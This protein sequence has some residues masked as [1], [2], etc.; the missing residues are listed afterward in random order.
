MPEDEKT[1]D[2]SRRVYVG[3]LAYKT[4]WQDLKDHFNDNEKVG[5][6]V[7]AD[8][9]VDHKTNVPSVSGRPLSKGCGT[10]EF[11]SAEDA[12]T[13]I[14]EMN[15]TELD[16]RLI[17][18]REDRDGPPPP[19]PDG[20]GGKGKGKGKD[21]G[22]G[23]WRCPNRDC[24]DLQFARNTQCRQ[25][26][27][28]RP[29]GDSKRDRSRSRSRSRRRRRRH[30]SR[31]RRKSRRDRP[32]K[33]RRSKKRH[34]RKDDSSRSR[35]K[36]GKEKNKKEKSGNDKDVKEKF[37][38]GKA[39]KEDKKD[40]RDDKKDGK[41]KRKPAEKNV[42]NKKA[43][44]DKKAKGESCSKEGSEYEYDDYATYSGSGA[45][46]G[47]YSDDAGSSSKS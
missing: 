13:A 26:G 31:S 45:S 18:V 35:R 6:V 2:R 16:G 15:D 12:K 43:K 1:I 34:R 38:K 22:A 11:N 29:T 39:K 33:R 10:V 46:D 21:K 42:K 5:D 7:S 20:K 9:M 44:K 17:F 14:A 41:S 32:R 28:P 23:D 30:R 27:E 8:I 40:K 37:S 4:S 19:R 24:N 36:S 3:N 47:E 25:C